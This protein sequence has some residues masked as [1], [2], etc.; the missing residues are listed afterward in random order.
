TCL[1]ALPALLAR[2]A[3]A[4]VCCIPSLQALVNRQCQVTIPPCQCQVFSLAYPCTKR[5]DIISEEDFMY[6]ES[7]MSSLDIDDTH[8]PLL[9]KSSII[10]GLLRPTALL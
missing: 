8:L 9:C 4:M 3:F 6:Q 1:R 2:F 10:C 7:R 5:L